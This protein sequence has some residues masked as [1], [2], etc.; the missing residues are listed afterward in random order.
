MREKI[1]DRGNSGDESDRGL[2]VWTHR[3]DVDTRWGDRDWTTREGETA[4]TGGRRIQVKSGT[5]MFQ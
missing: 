2:S 4:V 5:N 3:W 1:W